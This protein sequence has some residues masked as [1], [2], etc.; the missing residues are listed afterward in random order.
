MFEDPLHQPGPRR[1]GGGVIAPL[2]PEGPHLDHLGQLIGRLRM[3]GHPAERLSVEAQHLHFADGS[4]RPVPWTRRDQADFAEAL[5]W[6]KRA[7]IHIA[8]LDALDELRFA[9]CHDV[10]P[11]SRLALG[12]NDVTAPVPAC[13]SRPAVS[14]SNDGG[15]CG[16]AWAKHS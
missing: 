13:R 10:K 9:R 7:H 4:H 16:K 1:Q 12:H 3:V 2:W 8:V 5:A 11:V 14:I 6:S 15:A